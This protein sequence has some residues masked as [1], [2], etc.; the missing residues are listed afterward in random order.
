MFILAA[1]NIYIVRNGD[2]MSQI[3]LLDAET[4]NQIAAGE[5]VERPR[6][7]V[8]ELVENAIDAGAT[9]ITAEIKEG[10]ISFIR[11][12]DN[13]SGIAPQDMELAFTAHATSKIAGIDDLQ[14]ISSL[15]FRG[16]ALSSIA[17]VSMVETITK[18]REAV[19]GI[20]YVIEGGEKKQME[21]IGCPDGTTFIV[22][23]L[24][25]NTPARR[26]FLKTAATEGAYISDLMER[27][28]IS[29]PGVACK[30]IVNGQVKLQT[31][32]NGNIRDI[33]YH[34]YG[35]DIQNNL[36]ELPA[37]DGEYRLTGYIGKPVISRGNRNYMNYFVNGRYVKNPIIDKAILDAYK[38]YVMQHRF[39]FVVLWMETPPQNLD[40]N[41]HPTKMEVRFDDGE[42]IYALVK[43]VLSEALEQKEL[44][45][46]VSFGREEKKTQ[47][48]SALNGA[49]HSGKAV[50]GAEPFETK[51]LAKEP[52]A[53]YEDF[54]EKA[55]EPKRFIPGANTHS[56][57]TG[58]E[59][60]DRD[61][62]N[63]LPQPQQMKPNQEELQ[64]IQQTQPQQ[65]KPLETQPQQSEMPLVQ[66]DGVAPPAF[67]II[68]QLF[69]T[70]WIV[71]FEGEML[72]IDQH[73]AHEKVLYERLMAQ[74]QSNKPATQMINPPM[75]LS[76]S[77][78]EEQ[79]FLENQEVF[80]QL[81]FAIA[82][83]GGREYAVNGVP[84]HLPALADR[85]LLMEV[86]DGLSTAGGKKAAPEILLNRIAT[87]SCKAAV[88]GNQRLDLSEAV[89][90]IEQLMTLE[91]PY[92]CPHGRPTMIR[93]SKYELEKKFKRIV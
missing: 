26:K 18:T 83:F 77:M 3:N 90:L 40:V 25:Y 70:Y 84:F 2:V 53:A 69:Q 59:R 49:A 56:S 43:A 55:T 85:E 28:A 39:P 79:L 7:V 17:A 34:I 62:S 31:S 46:E 29:N 27:L 24:F 16:E 8:K 66:E 23:N 61:F 91:N 57:Q 6:A 30:L 44:I 75:V 33:I 58:S 21:E 86:F 65:E 12:T 76:L 42:Q 48:M 13:G 68:G 45:P 78:T 64:Q 41:V 20:R 37:D 15:G 93:M 4:V 82:P 89:S 81:G 10:G 47:K 67:S 9:M 54:L 38:P 22:R 71:E 5:V 92:H 63:S 51:R 19:T 87:M 36:I 80:E 60:Q 35:R 50:H 72:V 73:A 11:I 32:G 74:I 1:K 14:Q 52:P 88:K